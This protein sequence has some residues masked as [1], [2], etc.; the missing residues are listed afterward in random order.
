MTT[1]TNILLLNLE[2]TLQKLILKYDVLQPHYT[3]NECMQI[4]HKL[5]QMNHAP[6]RKILQ[7]SEHIT[8]EALRW[9]HG[10]AST[11]QCYVPCHFFNFAF[12]LPPLRG[13]K[14]LWIVIAPGIM[15]NKPII[16]LDGHGLIS[17]NQT[18]VRAKENIDWKYWLLRNIWAA[19]D[20]TS[21][22]FLI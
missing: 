21:L 22:P 6:V 16:I 10:R 15:T 19:G 4:V 14:K 20:S 2:Y 17:D 1:K 13:V 18:K 7:S 11:G 8:N 9:F 12:H 5:Y 3:I